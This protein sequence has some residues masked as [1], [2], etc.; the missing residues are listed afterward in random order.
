MNVN[1]IRSG[2]GQVQLLKQVQR[3]SGSAFQEEIE[4]QSASKVKEHPAALTTSEKQYFEQMFPSAAD[5]IRTYNPFQR[6]GAATLAKLGSLI[7]RKG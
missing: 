7:D 4:K 3:S 6:D 5:E 1:D 2:A